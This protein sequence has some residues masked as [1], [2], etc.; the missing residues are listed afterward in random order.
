MLKNSDKEKIKIK[1][2]EDIRFYNIKP[3]NKEKNR[4]NY[5]IR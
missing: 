5:Q 4:I 1:L 2:S 3:P